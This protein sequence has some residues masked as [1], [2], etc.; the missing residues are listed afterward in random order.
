MLDL[1]KKALG[2]IQSMLE[3]RMAG[4]MKPKAVSVEVE[5]VGKKPGEVG[6]D[7]ANEPGEGSKPEEM[8]D[9]QELKHGEGAELTQGGDMD[10]LSPDE[11][12][13]L[14]MLLEKMGC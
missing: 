8:Q 12:Q 3:D 2:G 10:K 5:A 9:A 7:E 4:R 13:Q 14:Q 1:K 6:D 11:Q